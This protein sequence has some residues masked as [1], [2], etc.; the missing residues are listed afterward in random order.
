VPPL[1]IQSITCADG[2]ATLT[3]SAVAGKV[4]RVQ[5]TPD[6]AATEW[7]DL[8]PDVTA[9][10]PTASATDIVSDTQRFYRILL[11]E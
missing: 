2:V 11:V 4:Y 5:F 6:P 10:G 8:V 3:W 7:Q 1:T 9:T